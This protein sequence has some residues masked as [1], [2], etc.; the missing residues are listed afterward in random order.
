MFSHE[1]YKQ[2][3]TTA[4]VLYKNNEPKYV[5]ALNEDCKIN[6][7]ADVIDEGGTITLCEISMKK[8]ITEKLRCTI[9]K[10][11]LD[12]GAYTPVLPMEN[13]YKIDEGILYIRYDGKNVIEVPG[14]F[15]SVDKFDKN[16]Y[17]VNKEK[18]FFTYYEENKTYFIY[19]NTM[20]SIWRTVE[21]PRETW[22]K[23]IQF[24]NQD[25]GFM[26]LFKSTAGGVAFGNIIKTTDGGETWQIIS[27]G[28]GSEEEESFKTGSEIKFFDE[29]LGFLTMPKVSGENSDIYITRD[30]GKTFSK[31]EVSD[32]SL[33]TDIYDY[34]NL[35][36]KEDGI[37]YLEIG[38]GADGDYI[39]GDSKK[40][41]SRDNAISWR[42]I[43]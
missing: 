34:Y 3:G 18:T 19:S 31:L 30:G 14:D 5:I 4:L 37:Y 21:L 9:Y 16:T 10:G 32:N 8:T 38:Q 17:Q 23:D 2:F 35:P 26:L 15:E 36:T 28:I 39:G 12:N 11:D 22:V 24:I 13:D 42:V 27:N 29:N 40:Y 41:I 7:K 1:E 6:E 33:Q 25:L 20:G 43:E